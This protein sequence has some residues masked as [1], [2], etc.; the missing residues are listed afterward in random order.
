M[1]IEN[2]KHLRE[3]IRRND[4][5]SGNPF[6]IASQYLYTDIWGIKRTAYIDMYGKKTKTIRINKREGYKLNSKILGKFD[7]TNTS[8]AYALIADAIENAN[9]NF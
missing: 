5:T 1:N 6:V 3:S 4:A 8:N 9:T 7:T 2:E